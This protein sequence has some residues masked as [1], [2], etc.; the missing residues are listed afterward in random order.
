M[1]TLQGPLL[2]A[3]LLCLLWQVLDTCLAADIPVAGYVG[4]GYSSDLTALA[5]RHCLLHRAAKEMWDNY[6]LGQPT[7]LL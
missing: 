1:G 2:S 3:D 6:S 5:R 7:G 4:G